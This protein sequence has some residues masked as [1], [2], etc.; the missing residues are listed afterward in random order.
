MNVKELVTV[1]TALKGTILIIDDSPTNIKVLFHFLRDAGFKVLVAQDGESALQ[2]AAYAPPDM[3]LLDVLMPGIDGFETCYR[4]KTNPALCDIPVIFM[5]ASADAVDRVKGLRMGA[6][7]YI[8]KPF[9]SEEVL[10]RV[11]THLNLRNLTKQLQEQAEALEQRVEARTFELSQSNNLLRQSE[12]QLRSQ[13][14]QLEESLHKLQQTQAQLVQTEKISSL[15][16]LVAGIAHEVNNPVN[17]IAGNLSIANGYVMDLLGLLTLYQQHLPTPPK[18]I[19]SKIREMD[20]EF[21]QTD[22]PKMLVSMKVG[23]DRIREITSSLR[24]FSRMD[25]A[26]KQLANIHEGIESTLLIL[27]HRLQSKSSAPAIELIKDYGN[28]PLVAC[29][30]GQLNQVF[31]NLIANAIDALEESISQGQWA[32]GT[33]SAGLSPTITIQTAVEG[34]RVVIR[35]RDNGPGISQEDCQKLFNP[36]FTTKP[37]DKGTGL[38][39]SVSQQIVAEKHNGRLSCVSRPNSGAEFMIEIP[40]LDADSEDL[41]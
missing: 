22:L 26:Q 33:E 8:T 16:Q 24:T 2:R 6:V 36:F 40:L 11:S 3:I 5:T 19:Q 17:F 34:D 39:L 31:M 28:L 27:Q 1:E 35:I 32:A 18:D 14:Q 4:L 29:Y 9:Q 38:G 37:V 20:W 7:D 15:G 21:V 13:T 25:T 10:A 30:I 23:T 41:C 12:A